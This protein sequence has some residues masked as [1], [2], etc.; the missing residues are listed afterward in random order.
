MLNYGQQVVV[1]LDSLYLESRSKPVK[2]E[3]RLGLVKDRV[4]DIVSNN[5]TVH[6]LPGN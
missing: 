6:K 3:N 4:S 1:H 5:R 2:H